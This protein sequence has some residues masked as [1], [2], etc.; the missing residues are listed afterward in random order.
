MRDILPHLKN[1][2]INQCNNIYKLVFRKCY[3]MAYASHVSSH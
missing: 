2:F 1:L 3:V